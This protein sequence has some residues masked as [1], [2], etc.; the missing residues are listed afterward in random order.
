AG[1]G[2]R[3]VGRIVRVDPRRERVTASTKL[4]H[5]SALAVGGA[6]VLATDFWG[7]AVRRLDPAT[8]SVTARLGLTLPYDFVPGDDAFLPESI[9]VGEKAIWVST[10]RGVLA[11]VDPRL[12]RVDYSVRLP[13]DTTGGIV[14]GAGAVWVAESLLGVARVDPVRNRVVARI[15]IDGLAVDRVVYAGGQIFAIGGRTSG[16]ALSGGSAIARIDP[17][18]NRIRAVM[19]FPDGELVIAGS[20]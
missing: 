18:R 15:R 1:D 10:A 11:R 5:P 8:L 17:R 12:T 7:N 14:V 2:R 20:A 19:S 3:S 13:P 4:A 6:G 9:T 16:G